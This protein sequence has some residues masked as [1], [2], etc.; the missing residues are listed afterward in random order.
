MMSDDENAASDDETPRVG[1]KRK[2]RALRWVIPVV[3]VVVIAGVAGVV[4]MNQRA[5]ANQLPQTITRDIPATMITLTDTVSTTGTMEP[6]QRADLAFS[7]AG[8]V[9][10]VSVVV[11]DKVKSGQALASIDATDL[12]S[13][14]DSAQAAVDA[15]QS[16]YDTA[17][18][19]GVSAQIT[20]AKSVLATKKD[21]LSNAKTAL[22]AATLKAPFD[23]TVAIVSLS[24]GD[25]VGGGSAGGN[26]SSGG[27]S[28]GG[29]GG[30]SNSTSTSSGITVISTDKYAVSTSV[31]S[32][33]VIKITKGL[34]AEITPNGATQALKGTVTSVGVMATSSSASGAEFP[35][36][37]DITDALP[38]LY[39]GVTA[40][41]AI[42]TQ[43]RQVLAVPT[44][45]ITENQGKATVELRSGSTTVTTEVTVG[46]TGN[47]MTEITAGLKQGDV[48]VVTMQTGGNPNAT[49]GGGIGLPGG[50]GG[51][52]PSRSPGSDGGYPGGYPSGGGGGANPGGRPS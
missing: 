3:A 9:K 40:S 37:I 21:A 7:S 45:A 33:D 46:S 50:M 41:V 42:I 8:T 19:G 14:V 44:A 24:V 30:N 32:S 2:R 5:S 49:Q 52:R 23:G 20:A 16:D 39:S 36:T 34:S 12:Q 6:A 18:S 47:G 13:A 1:P 38:G 31:G 17:V 43:S 4:V 26:S 11:G 51:G 29:S 25:E 28:Y 15:A 10:K 22:A 35:V 48:V 27:G